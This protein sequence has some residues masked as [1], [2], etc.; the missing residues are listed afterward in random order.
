[1][2]KNIN[3][4]SPFGTVNTN[5]GSAG[6]NTQITNSV[7][8]TSTQQLVID[9]F[10]ANNTISAPSG[11][12]LWSSSANSAISD[13]GSSVAANGGSTAVHWTVN[14]GDWGDIGVPLNPVA[15]SVA[16]TL[17]DRL[18][19]TAAGN[20]GIGTASPTAVLNVNGATI[21]QGS[22]AIENTAGTNSND[23][24]IQRA[25]TISSSNIQYTFNERTNNT[26]LW[27]YG[28][29]GSTFWDPVKL[30]WNGGS[31]AQV[32][33]LG[34]DGGNV[35]VGTTSASHKLEVA[36]SGNFSTSVLSPL[37][38]TATG[39]ALDIGL[40]NASVINLDEN[41][42]VATNKSFTA[43]G[44]ALFQDATNS[45]AA[46]QVQ[47]ATAAPIFMVD[48]TSAM[49]NGNTLNYLT[50]PGFESGSFSN[51][52]AGWN[53]VSP[54]TL[55]QNTNKTQV[56]NGADS[57]QVVTTSSNGGLTTGSFVSAPPSGTY[58]VSFY[59]KVASGSATIA[60]TA[61]TVQSTDGATH[62][63]SPAAGITIN[64]SGFQRL[65]CSITATGAITALQITQTDGTA[66]T[67][68]FD[69]MQLQSNSYN[70][71]TLTAPTVYQIGGIQLRGAI[72]S[73]VAIAANGD[74]TSAFQVQSA[75]GNTVLA[76][77]T[78]DS[79]LQLR[80]FNDFAPGGTELFTSSESFPATAGWTSISG[81]G[82]S[83]TATHTASGGT[84][85][86]NASP[87]ITPTVGVTYKIVY[88][89]SG[90]TTGTITA[91]IGGATGA[92]IT[93][94]A[95]RTEY[96][97][98][99]TTAPFAMT[100]TTD[101]NGTITS[102]SIS[103]LVNSTPVIQVND[104]SGAK[105]L[106]IRAGGINDG[107][108][109]SN[110]LGI[111]YG[112]L[113]I[114][115]AGN[116]V[117]IG[118]NSMAATTS[119]GSNVAVG[120]NSLQNNI[121][122]AGNVGVGLGALKL[123]TTGADNVAMGFAAIQ[124][125]T[126]SA[127]NVGLG[128]DAL[129]N[130]STGN[131][132]TAVGS[133]AMFGFST[134]TGSGNAALGDHAGYD[135]TSASNNT[136]VGF[137]AG[138]QGNSQSQFKSF[139]TTSVASTGIGA[140][141]QTACS[142]SCLVLGGQGADQA[143]VG[144]GTPNPKNFFDVE[145]T[146]TAAG[147][148]TTDG[149]TGS[150]TGSGTNFTSSM[151]GD[152]VYIASNT[153][154]T[155][156]YS[157]VIT[158]VGGTTSMTVSPVTFTA[159]SGASYYIN[160]PGFQVKTDGTVY[161]QGTSTTQFQVQNLAA[162][163]QFIVDTTNSRVYIGDGSASATPTILVLDSKNTTDS[164]TP[165]T[166]TCTT[167][168]AIFY[169]STDSQFRACRNGLLFNLI[170]G[171]DV[172]TF[173]AAS[174]TWTAPSGISTVMVVACGGGGS[175]GG[176]LT[177]LTSTA[178]GGG[179]G[180]G[181]GARA[182]LIMAAADAGTSQTVVV[183]QQVSGGNASATGTAGNPTTFGGTMVIAF[184]GGRGNAGQATTGPSGG[185]G[186]GFGVVGGN[187]STTTVSGGDNASANAQGVGGAGGG[188][189]TAAA[190][191]AAELGGGGGGGSGIGTVGLA[192]GDSI[193]GGAGGGGG[194]GA[195]ASNV[196]ANGASGGGN[197]TYASGD[198]V[199]GGAGNGS[200]GTAGNSIHCG[201]GGAGGGGSAAGTG[202]TGGPGGAAGGG[203]GGGGGGITGG[204]GGAGAAGKVWVFS[205]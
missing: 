100:P 80:N 152:T 111:G 6:S 28:Y 113:Q 12:Q 191:K 78:T 82:S 185:G 203:G 116:N 129:V 62:T 102:L 121:T 103:A 53:S 5:S 187:G 124:N 16:D 122:G 91:S 95:P 51:A 99:T 26:D 163:A 148:V 204:A 118:N 195:N 3:T 46:F 10:T 120:V 90:R 137:Q 89:S 197:G 190:G 167:T 58:I 179:S 130:S 86:L 200:T 4:S 54:G 174:S 29:D 34:S 133:N 75:S 77:D 184:G 189:T 114:S 92:A 135:I 50:Y 40:N 110:I 156:T 198:G 157:G 76:V 31:G 106:E 178:R 161:T 158:A 196:A 140:F 8:T 192:G 162:T 84:T 202:S 142:T 97:Y 131:N 83:A 87:T 128:F 183:G 134:I 48:T 52:A 73:P 138:Y 149:T 70:S 71:L 15:N 199:A 21:L 1:V 136:F 93:N 61:F 145:P 18:H 168:G 165:G 69:A 112:A 98:A 144:I 159:V 166:T 68:Y 172:Q 11:T 27:L 188:D 164:L 96:L 105:A 74:S 126:T 32:L 81:T 170:A 150:V 205:W 22:T 25:G 173:T 177:G 88:T 47:N 181:G 13:T 41:T 119:G 67:L 56:Y 24:T 66:R 180:G 101:Y 19:I 55:S 160:A 79:Q 146:I 9:A 171:V 117:A 127:F 36:G 107:V 44:A 17:A 72:T 169:N 147:T 151:I 139:S 115:A 33:A 132:N 201:G 23:L 38:D 39:V 60:S 104:S 20:V 186:G 2:Y 123:N 109:S 153:P 154:L 85:A 14:F 65:Y 143:N 63:C 7:A 176:G 175:G 125:G 37:F 141:A 49:A 193:W 57:A 43:N 42:A 155:Q 35:A 64:S 45:S 94:A 194:G 108:V 59:A 182:S 30:L